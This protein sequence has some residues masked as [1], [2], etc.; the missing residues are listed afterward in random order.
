MH[1]LMLVT[2]TMLPGETSPEAR[3]RIYTQLAGD[4]SFCG[5]G[6]RFGITLGDW[7]VIG[8]RWSG[9]L[10]ETVMGNAYRDKLAA[11]FSEFTASYYSKDR[12]KERAGELDALW[13]EF[14]GSGP[15]TFNR[16]AYREIGYDDDAM[17]LDRTLYDRLLAK[18]QGESS[19]Q[20]D[21]LHCSLVDLDDEEL[22]ETFIGRKW[23][24]VVDYHS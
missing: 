14:G 8:G 4:S 13:R 3:V 23:I 17:P 21:R 10:R 18:Y 16:D 19:Q 20:V 1:Y 15:S 2:L 12:V 5:D 22:D 11:T 24:A 7:F 9:M 6:G